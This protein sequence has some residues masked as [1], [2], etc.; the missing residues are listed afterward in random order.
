MYPAAIENYVRPA[1]ID[2][3]L[4][5]VT[6]YEAGEAMFIAGGQSLM[7][8]VKSRLVRPRCVV[9]LQAVKDLRGVS[10]GSA[11]VRI[12]A[13]TRYA[14]IAAESRLTGAYEA[15]VDAAS[16]VGDRQVRNRGT[17]GGSLCWNYVAACMPAA[18]LGVGS[19]MELISAAGRKRTVTADDFIRGPLETARE[20][21]EVLVAITLPAVSA[22]AGSAYKKWG[23][24]TDALP[25][26]GVS[27]YIELDGGGAIAK[28]RFAVGG[29]ASGPKRARGAEA[30]LVGKKAGDDKGIA[31]AVGKA[32]A[33][34]ETQ[35]DIWADS[36]YRK[37]LIRSLGAEVVA[38]AFAR[39]SGK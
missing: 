17:I 29:L 24:V 10:A 39:A 38:S 34:I 18:N 15:L 2:E 22:K 28:A 31:E 13:M 4:K 12:G 3:A 5:A 7:Q 36:D 32:A 30:A 20:D 6:K 21:D 8:A 14:E 9:D 26:V 25:V 16:H 23:L 19:S 27:V 11:G 37:N 1:S 35:S 33:E